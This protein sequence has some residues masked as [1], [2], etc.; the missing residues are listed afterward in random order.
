MQ[1]VQKKLKFIIRVKM[2]KKLHN[3]HFYLNKIC[4]GLFTIT[5]KIPKMLNSICSF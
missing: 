4:K 3:L 2:G 1:N 5:M